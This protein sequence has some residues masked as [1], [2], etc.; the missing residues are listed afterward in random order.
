VSKATTTKRFETVL[1]TGGASYIASHAVLA[2]QDTHHHA[3]VR[4][5]LSNGRRQVVTLSAAF[6]EGDIADI[7]PVKTVIDAHAATSVI[8][9]SGSMVV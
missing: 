4:D 7:R 5:I 1:V 8:H 3:V 2:Q 9:F 6:C